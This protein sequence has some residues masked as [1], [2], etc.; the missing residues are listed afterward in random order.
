M[1]RSAFDFILAKI[2]ICSPSTMCGSPV[3]WRR[4]GEVSEG[5]DD[6]G[7]SLPKLTASPLR[8]QRNARQC[9]NQ[10][11][12]QSRAGY[13][14]PRN[15]AEAGVGSRH[16]GALGRFDHRQERQAPENVVKHQ[17][18]RHRHTAKDRRY[19]RWR[20]Q[21]GG[22]KQRPAGPKSEAD[23]SAHR[24]RTGLAQHQGGGEENHVGQR[25]GNAVDFVT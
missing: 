4:G 6:V 14:D 22:E 17:K 7:R 21:D 11:R 20:G 25:H 16:R 24:S 3:V 15:D 12:E 19:W 13:H 9:D 23:G 18:R 1:N 8:R 10:Q 5:G 2:L